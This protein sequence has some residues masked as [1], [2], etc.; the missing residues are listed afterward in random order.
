ME[1]ILAIQIKRIGDLILTAPAL[2]RLRQARPD[3][4]ITLVTMGAAGQL[5]SA[6]PAVDTHFSYR[7]QRPNL[8][9][10]GN[11]LTDRYDTV[12]DFNGTDR[13]AFM[14][15]MTRAN[16]RVTYTKRAQGF[17]RE[18]TYTQTS[19][20]KLRP[21][22]T[23]DHMCAL[24]D[25]IG[26]PSTTGLDSTA[27]LS[28]AIPEPVQHRVDDLLAQKGLDGPFAVVHPGTARLEKY[29]KADRWAEVIR[30]CSDGGRQLSCV[31]TGGT[32][33]DETRHLDEIIAHLKSTGSNAPLVLAGQLSLLETA[34]VIR[35]ATLALG[36]DTAAMHLAS[37]FQI[38]QVV[39]FGPTNPFHWR[40]RH[41]EARIILSGHEG[42]MTETDYTM[43]LEERSMHAI[44]TAQVIKA[45][46]TLAK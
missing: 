17:W 35:R 13:S 39:L 45:I 10:W 16:Q 14:T 37:A 18:Q 46:D 27:P 12:L 42:V 32:D 9:L 26:V 6:I 22:H 8:P 21:F 19:N 30:E 11:L 7:Y 38:P 33:P 34:A 4:H 40:P 36:V 24:L 43:R 15:W 20:A 44:Q 5:V 31:I 29:W 28:L 25:A 2:S 23:V 41:P 1:R 3:A